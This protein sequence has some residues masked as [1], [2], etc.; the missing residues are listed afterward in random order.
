MRRHLLWICIGLAACGDDRAA[1][2]APAA[3]TA[4]AADAALCPAHGVLEVLCTKC[5]PKLIPIF[6]AKGDFCEAHGL[7]LSICPVHH[8]ERGGR[9]ATEV[10]AGADAA[11][12]E[13]TLVRLASADTARLAGIETTPATARPGGARLEVLA[14]ITY[15]AAGWAQ[16]N[17]RADGVVREIAADIGAVVARGAPLAVI[18]SAA[19][20]AD[21][22][23]VRAAA[24]RVAVADESHRREAS[25]QQQGIAARKDVLAAQ[26]ELDAARAELATARAALGVIGRSA[27]GS[28]Y[29]LTAPIAGVVTRRSVTIGHMVGSAQEVLFEIVDTRRMR[30][31]LAIPE[32]D[33]RRVRVGQDIAVRVDALPD[34]VFAGRID[35]IA[36]EVSRETRTTVARAALDNPDGALRANMFGR[37]H[38]ALGAAAASVTVPR[39]AVQ[40]VAD[41]D[42]VFVQAAPGEYAVRRVATGARE[43]DRV[44]LTAGVAAGEPVVT[45]GSF[46]LK[47]ETLK[48]SIGAG[49]CE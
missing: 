11:P 22:S 21:Q 41:V 47:T 1:P 46:L 48:G 23:R 28:R 36:P 8:P 19:V 14:S 45:T 26:Q 17:A 31:Q 9:P 42:L 30:A 18:E 49:C 25:L 10:T 24:S 4:T 12:A 35:Y 20:G 7:P 27:G 39:S 32:A 13:G 37:A 15:D 44:E 5:H 16:V 2:T 6:R 43:G 3:A 29:V 34:E 38:I 40:R 33:L